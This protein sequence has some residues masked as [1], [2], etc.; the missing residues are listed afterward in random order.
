MTLIPVANFAQQSLFLPEPFQYLTAVKYSLL[1][2]NIHC[3]LITP[4]RQLSGGLSH[5]HLFQ[6]QSL[7]Q[8]QFP[9]DSQ[10]GVG[11]NPPN[12]TSFG[13]LIFKTLSRQ[14]TDT[15]FSLQPVIF[16]YSVYMSKYICQNVWSRW[17][18]YEVKC[19]NFKVRGFQFQFIKQLKNGH[20]NFEDLPF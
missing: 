3:P 6:Q 19:Q 20:S 10:V 11:H 18:V 7:P 13:S 5:V 8:Q 16:V 14:S 2:S 1:T 12:P 15:M 17:P 4:S 9:F